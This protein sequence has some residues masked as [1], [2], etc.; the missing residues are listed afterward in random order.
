MDINVAQE[1]FS[2]LARNGWQERASQI[3]AS[4]AAAQ[5]LSVVDAD[6]LQKAVTENAV[7]VPV[8]NHKLYGIIEGSVIS[9]LQFSPL[10]SDAAMRA[11]FQ[12]AVRW[13]EIETSSQCNRRCSYCP[14]SKN[15]RHSENHFMPWEMFT[16]LIGELAS[17]HYSGAIKFVGNNEFFLHEE[18]FDYVRHAREKLPDARFELFSNG[19]FLT[20]PM[21]DRVAELKVA[22]INVTLH[23]APTRPYQEVD[24]LARALKL[25]RKLEVGLALADFAENTR[26]W[27]QGNYR[28]INLLVHN[29]NLSAVGHNWGSYLEGHDKQPRTEPCTYPLR[30]LILNYKGE[31]FLCCRSF[32]E[33]D[34]QTVA[35]GLFTTKLEDHPDVFHAYA[36][37]AHV[38]KRACLFTNQPKTGPCEHCDGDE[39]VAV[40]N[41]QQLLANIE[42]R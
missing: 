7:D 40:Q 18:N 16:K 42:L 28:G 20:R 26:I 6:C 1:Y 2:T 37:P 31:I 25:S 15:D 23:S 33:A 24:T 12:Q 38:S 9:S 17:I 35:A 32:K 30:Q 14:N 27:F 4:L 3:I 19:D 29:D 13:I 41:A 21:L 36:S 22:Q 39:R 8:E 10:E 5:A 34:E 11:S